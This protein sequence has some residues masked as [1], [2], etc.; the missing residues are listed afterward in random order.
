MLYT[1]SPDFP[2]VAV[3][4]RERVSQPLA[5]ARRNIHRSGTTE[6]GKQ[7]VENTKLTLILTV[8]GGGVR[9]CCAAA[10]S[11]HL[12]SYVSQTYRIKYRSWYCIFYPIS[13][14][15]VEKWKNKKKNLG[16]GLGFKKKKLHVLR[17]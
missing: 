7:V 13:N 1:S 14:L 6:K 12:R 11:D 5:A 17:L 4:P 15:M 10:V 8:S 3:V 16:L 9:G 2:K